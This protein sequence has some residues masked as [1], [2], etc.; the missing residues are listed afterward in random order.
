MTGR[1]PASVDVIFL[2]LVMKNWRTADDMVFVPAGEFW[3]G[4]DPANN[5]GYPC[6]GAAQHL[7][8]LDAY[9]I[10]RTE[11][12]N[13]EYAQCVAAGSCTPLYH[14]SSALRP[15]YYD[16]P[17]Y[18]AY[19]VTWVDYR[20]ATAFCQWAG[21][22]LPTEAEWQK[23][24]RGSDDTRP[25]PWGSV[26]PNCTLANFWPG[27]GCVGDTNAAGSYP[28]GASPYGALDMAGSLWEWVDG[29]LSLLYS[30][31][32]GSSANDLRVFA[33][34]YE[35]PAYRDG[36]GLGFRCVRSLSSPVNDDMVLIPAGDFQMGCDP[37]HNGSYPCD[38]D[39]L[40]LHTVYLDA[41]R[42]DR[43]EVTN[44]QYG[45]CVAAGDCTPPYTNSSPTRPSYF[46]NPTYAAYPVINVSWYQADAYCR[47]RG[48]RLPTEA[49]WE[50]AARGTEDTRAFPWG[51]QPPDCT[52]ANFWGTAACV[53]DTSVAG[54]YPDGASP[55]GILD[56]AGNVWEWVNDWWQV[57]YYSVSPA[58]NPSG[59][60][61]G[62]HKVLRGGGWNLY[63]LGSN[64]RVASRG[65]VEPSH[66]YSPVF[67]FRCAAAPEQ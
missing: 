56:M 14:N 57:D 31:G 8:Y 48:M 66:P 53:G 20:Q 26:S 54:S 35:N 25:Y 49:E 16:N 15:S 28:A 45:R 61:A 36:P 11:V 44:Y 17:A 41:Y 40:P 10:D 46:G 4:C 55:Y 34:H 59:P 33:H 7:V 39:E 29:G 47:W 27:P 21:K 1:L 23:A 63:D 67:G 60:T 65:N 43:T 13:A 37:A 51:D 2:P 30:G 9:Y 32:A 3:M 18:A 38:R 19:P 58:S 6:T 42:I 5:G 12:T 24:A 62:V 52:L 50:K 64:L 22:R